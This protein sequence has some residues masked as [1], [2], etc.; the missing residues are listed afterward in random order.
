MKNSYFHYLFFS[1]VILVIGGCGLLGDKDQR[2]LSCTDKDLSGEVLHVS[3]ARGYDS[4]ISALGAENLQERYRIEG[5]REAPFYVHYKDNSFNYTYSVTANEDVFVR[6]QITNGQLIDS[7]SIPKGARVFDINGSFLVHSNPTN[8]YVVD[9]GQLIPKGFDYFIEP[10][11][12][13]GNQNF[14]LYGKEES[15][16]FGTVDTSGVSQIYELADIIREVIPNFSI[17]YDMFYFEQEQRLLFT[18][19]DFSNAPSTVLFDVNITN[20]EYKALPV[21]DHANIFQSSDE[22]FYFLS[23]QST[24]RLNARPDQFLKVYDKR[25]LKLI[26]LIDFKNEIG[27]EVYIQDIANDGCSIFLAVHSIE[28]GDLIPRVL[29]YDIERQQIVYIKEIETSAEQ[30]S[31][32]LSLT[33]ESNPKLNRGLK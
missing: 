24:L 9:N 5:L 14:A 17:A 27:S 31:S 7:L 22:Q 11:Q 29:K 2:I 19:E 6:R 30:A 23:H 33:I 18:V 15:L 10:I 1:F 8:T 25:N 28:E 20:G 32:I 3:V 26:N 21:G 16:F 12:T 4:Y 13:I